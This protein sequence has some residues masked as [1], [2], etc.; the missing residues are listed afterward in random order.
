MSN[1]LT[2]GLRPTHP[3]EILRED[4]FPA[5]GR[6]KAAIARLLGI[7]RRT[8]YDLLEEK[9]PITPQ[10]AL[11]IA[12]LTGTEAA[13]WLSLQQMYDLRIAEREIAGELKQIPR[14]EAPA[15]G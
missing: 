5:L 2:K 13:T 1:P 8:L 9:A 7:S 3:G 15:A 12:K 10:M 4:T 14:L 11:R 6:P